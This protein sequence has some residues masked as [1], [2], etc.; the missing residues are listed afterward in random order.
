M[1]G[2]IFQLPELANGLSQW[3]EI[4]TYME[5]L[6]L[7]VVGM[8]VT[9]NDWNAQDS[10]LVQ[11][12]LWDGMQLALSFILA[13]LHQPHINRSTEATEWTECDAPL[14]SSLFMPTVT[15]MFNPCGTCQ[16]TWSVRRQKKLSLVIATNIHAI[17]TK[18][19]GIFGKALVVE[20]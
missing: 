6:L 18:L 11:R 5:A 17:R 13:I 3:R 4:G 8:K 19:K 10:P 12:I 2:Y 9:W 14:L 20:A 7:L 15:F 1:G 16:Q